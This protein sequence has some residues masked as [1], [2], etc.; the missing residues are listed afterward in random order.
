VKPSHLLIAVPVL[1]LL[2]SAPSVAEPPP[3]GS[4]DAHAIL[5]GAFDY[6]RGPTSYT[7]IVMTVH[8]P[9]WE[10]KSAMKSW[11]SGQKD[12]LVRFTE[13]PKDAGS[14][15]LK[16]GD[17]MWIY[18]PKLEKVLK[19]PF[20]MMAQSW[21]GSDF[22]YSD[23]AKSDDLLIYYDL[24]IASTEKQD[25]HTVYVIDAVPHPDAPTIWGKQTVRV[26]DDHLLLEEIF[27]DQDL[28]PVKKLSATA[29]GPLGGKTY[30]TKMRMEKSEEPGH[31]TDLEYRS[32]EFGLDL[33]SSMFTVANLRN[34]RSRWERQ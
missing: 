7:E 15:T 34:P 6:W 21:M 30:V 9:D 22:S 1:G 3:S 27:Y 13:P 18:T 24:S 5:K 19:L 8:R 25:G 29:I 10:R 12:A 31:W 28:K 14:A 4:P 33:P 32:A 2:L 26:R 20:S 23:L 11:T 17:D 16:L